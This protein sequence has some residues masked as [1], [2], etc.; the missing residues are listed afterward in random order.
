MVTQYQLLGAIRPRGWFGMGLLLA[1]SLGLGWICGGPDLGSRKALATTRATRNVAVGLVVAMT[2]FQDTP[3]VTAV[4]AYGLVSI[5]GTLVCA[6]LIGR[7]GANEPED[8]RD[9]S[10]R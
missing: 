5:L 2:D 3:A 8:A 6:V 9:A 7:A 4:V 1:A 10:S